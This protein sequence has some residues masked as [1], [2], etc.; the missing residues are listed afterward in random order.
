MLLS[1]SI[2]GITKNTQQ[3][4]LV[5]GEIRRDLTVRTGDGC[6]GKRGRSGDVKVVIMMYGRVAAK[7]TVP[8]GLDTKAVAKTLV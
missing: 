2:R 1:G 3:P 7:T 5:V 6:K 4:D 8:A